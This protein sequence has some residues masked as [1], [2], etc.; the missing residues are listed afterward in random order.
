M[1]HYRFMIESQPVPDREAEYND[2]YDNSHLAD[3]LKLPGARLA[4]RFTVVGSEV[5]GGTRYFNF[6]DYETDDLPGLMA[7]IQA[8]AGTDAMPSSDAMDRESVK[9]TILAA[10][11][12]AQ[13]N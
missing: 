2:W 1:T 8:R 9:I 5:E 6:V 11:D 10:H 4:Q 13:S 12:V 3:I 7:E